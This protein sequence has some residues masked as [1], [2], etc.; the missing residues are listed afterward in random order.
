M[1]HLVDLHGTCDKCMRMLLTPWK[2]NME[3]SHGGL[4]QII[5]LSKWLMA[6]GSM[7][8]FQGVIS[9]IR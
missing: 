6:V 9:M 7:L 5:F 8:I 2:I 1:K 3:H 4:V